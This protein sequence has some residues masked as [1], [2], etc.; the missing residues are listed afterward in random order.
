ME[1]RPPFM[2][3]RLLLLGWGV[4]YLSVFLW[5][6]THKISLEFSY[7]YFVYQPGMERIL[8]SAFFALSPLFWL[9]RR[10]TRPSGFAV[11]M[12]YL[13]AYLP[14]IVVGS[15]VSRFSER[16]LLFEWLLLIALLLLSIVP[17]LPLISLPQLTLSS[18]WLLWGLL[19]IWAGGYVLLFRVFGL[20]DL[21]SLQEIYQVRLNARQILVSQGVLIG[22]LLRWFANVLN[23]LFLVIGLRRRDWIFFSVALLGQVAIFTFDATKFTLMSIPY[24]LGLYLIFTKSKWRLPSV[25][26]LQGSIALVI[27]GI[28]LDALLRTRLFLTYLVRRVFYVQGLLSALYFDYFSYSP[29][30]LWSHTRIARLFRLSPASMS[31]PPGPGFLIGEVYFNNPAGNANANFWADGF[32]NAGWYG[33]LLVTILLF[34]FLW[35]YDSVSLPNKREIGFLLMAMPLFALTNTALLT[36]F[37][38]HGWLLA[39]FLVWIWPVKNEISSKIV[40]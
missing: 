32:A 30:W 14:S 35:L 28:G 8:W 4:V 7:Q 12:L 6:Y 18:A 3:H 13:L 36:T 40:R 11:W 19:G 17:R 21:P 34:G 39:T 27:G 22:Y 37:L 26:L 10:I 15:Y 31:L 25:W 16:Y 9:P 2:A 38:S 5:V 20:R 29:L 24:L 33:V 23:P 1:S